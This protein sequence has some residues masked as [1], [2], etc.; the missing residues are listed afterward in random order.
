M[1]GHNYDFDLINCSYSDLPFV[2]AD[3]YLIG[4]KAR[5]I[6]IKAEMGYAAK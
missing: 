1:P 2:S 3:Q 5:S 6:V 4:E